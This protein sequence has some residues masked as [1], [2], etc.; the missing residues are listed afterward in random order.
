M[1]YPVSINV[2]P[3]LRERNRLTVGFR[4]ILAVPHIILAGG[5][6]IGFVYQDNTTLKIGSETGLLGAVAY[7]L[8]IVS[9]F[10]ILFGRVH[11]AGIRQFSMFYLR[12][13]V[14]ALAY[15]SLLSD[16][17]PPF[18][19]APFPASIEIVEPAGTRDRLSVALRIVLAVPHLIVLFFIVFAWLVTTIIAWFVI[20]FTGT[21]PQGLY[22]YGVG[23]LRWL[24]RV[25]AY[26]LLLVDDYPPFSLA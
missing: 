19:D 23:A 25:E 22:D 6:G 1:A 14:R 4:L 3:N 5:V 18:G 21:Y 20:L 15:L 26:M 13:R 24:L 11:L 7:V 9:W 12:W 2:D 16:A 17:Y 10:T 8:A